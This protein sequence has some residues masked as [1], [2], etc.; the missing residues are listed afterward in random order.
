Q[1]GTHPRATTEANVANMRR[2][3]HRLGLSHD[4][5]RSLATTD[6]DFVKWTQWI[7]LRIFDSCYDPD[8]PNVDALVGRARPIPELRQELGAGRIDPF[9]LRSEEHTSELQ[10]RFDL[11]CRLLLE[12]K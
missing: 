6:P 12:K 2:Q 1:T 5:R 8:A 11:V 3:L 9:A 7:F 4:P 10:S